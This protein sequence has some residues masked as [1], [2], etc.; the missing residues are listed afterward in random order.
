MIAKLFPWRIYPH[1]K[2]SLEWNKNSIELEQR[3]GKLH[4]AGADP[5]HCSR[6]VVGPKKNIKNKVCVFSK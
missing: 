5:G 4:I 1:R 2:F 3:H 6:G